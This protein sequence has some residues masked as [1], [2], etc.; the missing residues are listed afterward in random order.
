MNK[1]EF[2]NKYS[3][4]NEVQAFYQSNGKQNSGEQIPIHFSSLSEGAQLRVVLELTENESKRRRKRKK[5]EL[6]ANQ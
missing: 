3:I 4:S 6:I 2:E 1:Q 5:A